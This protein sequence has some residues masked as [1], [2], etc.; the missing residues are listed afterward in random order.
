MSDEKAKKSKGKGVYSK[1]VG[2]LAFNYLTGKHL[3]RTESDSFISAYMFARKVR[4]EAEQAVR[5]LK[6][7]RYLYE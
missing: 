3:H 1:S 5:D 4:K 2:E 7:S 6:K